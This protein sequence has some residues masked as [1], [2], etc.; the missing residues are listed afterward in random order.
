MQFRDILIIK[1]KCIK[2]LGSS[3]ALYL[4]IIVVVRINF[5]E[6]VQVLLYDVCVVFMLHVA[7]INTACYL[8][9]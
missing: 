2:I 1:P 9:R 5:V 6:S 3:P 7:V 4:S 8:K